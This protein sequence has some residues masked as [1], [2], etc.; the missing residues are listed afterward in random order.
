[1]ALLRSGKIDVSYSHWYT[2]GYTKDELDPLLKTNP[3]LKTYKPLGLARAR[4]FMRSDQPP[5]TDA[6]VRRAVSM[7]LDRKGWVD[8]LYAGEGFIHGTYFRDMPFGLPIEELGAA[9][10]NFKYNPDEAKRLLAEA[11]YAQGF[12]TELN[13]TSGYGPKHVEEIELIKDYLA[14]V[15][16]KAE[17]KIKE[18]TAYLATTAKGQYNG[19]GYGLYGIIED[20]DEF[21]FQVHSLSLGTRNFPMISDPTLDKMIEKQRQTVDP[22][23]RKDALDE[24]QRYLAEKM[25]WILMPG[26]ITTA[27]YQPW[28]KNWGPFRGYHA[29]RMLEVAWID[30]S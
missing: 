18:R 29:P 17:V 14:R 19:M 15:G 12:S 10:S 7:A 6:R 26:P 8:S 5:F 25:Y 11:G 28:L 20:P 21:L 16:I 1:M 27:A 23:K 9:A 30:K 13:G 24:V 2:G 3:E 4:L 22:G